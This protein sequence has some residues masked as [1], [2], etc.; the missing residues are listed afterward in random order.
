MKKAPMDSIAQIITLLN[1]LGSVSTFLL[2]AVLSLAGLW[3]CFRFV[4]ETKGV[5]LEWLERDL[6]AGRPL[7]QLGKG[8]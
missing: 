3:F 4:P 5:P 2:Y 7:R 8:N 6:H 1:R